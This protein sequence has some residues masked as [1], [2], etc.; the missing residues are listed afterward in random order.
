MDGKFVDRELLDKNHTKGNP[1]GWSVA[2]EGFRQEDETVKP[3]V[4]S[5]IQFDPDGMCPSQ[6]TEVTP[7]IRR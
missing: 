5:G 1:P 2:F 6:N 3:F 4:F 7:T